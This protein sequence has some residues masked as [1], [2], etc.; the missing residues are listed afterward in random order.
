M[1]EAREGLFLVNGCCLLHKGGNFFP[2]Q[3]GEGAEFLNGNISSA[4]LTQAF[5]NAG[6]EF[7]G[8]PLFSTGNVHHILCVDHNPVRDCF[9]RNVI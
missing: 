3:A 8:C 4:W 5:A 2:F 9:H 1:K 6:Q 7:L